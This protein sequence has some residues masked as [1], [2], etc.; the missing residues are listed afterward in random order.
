MN[1]KAVITAED[2]ATRVIKGFGQSINRVGKVAKIAAVAGI[3]ALTGAI[4]FSVKEAVESQKVTA[5]LEAV[6]KSTGK[7]AGIT[8]QAALD[9]ASSMQ[10]LTTFSDEEI[11]S[12]ENL[13]LTFTKI[14]KDIFPDTVKIVADMSTAL[15]QDLRSSS[16]QVGKALQDPILGVTALRRVGVNFNQTQTEVIK[17]LVKTGQSAEAQQ[18]ILK[19]LNLEF[20]GSAAAAA[21]TFGGRLKNLQNN[22]GEM[23]ETLGGLIIEQIE[24]FVVK[25]NDWVKNN[26]PQ[27]REALKQL[28]N[29]ISNISRKIG[30]VIAFIVK[31]KEAFIALGVLLL[32]V[33][34][35]GA[36][37]TVASNIRS[38][39][40]AIKGVSTA[41]Y[42]LA[43]ANPFALVAIAAV[44][45]AYLVVKAWQSALAA[46]EAVKN[47]DKAA[48][49]AGNSN[50]SVLRRLKDQIK[51]GT[52]AEQKRARSTLSGLTSN[53]TFSGRQH[54]GSVIGNKSYMVGERGPE[55]FVPPSGGGQI[56]P[57]SQVNR[58]A[59]TTINLSVNIGTFAGTPTERRKVAKDMLEALRDVASQQGTNLSALIAS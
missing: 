59:S 24:P 21:Q 29:A 38:I 17:N 58:N 16:I 56:V 57:N 27:I 55:M 45:A 9:L 46:I 54:G 36:I 12:A 13:L 32:S 44:G 28:V 42:A 22:F 34:V 19:E 23:A 51:N 39:A 25:L 7:T 31:W 10:Q 47:A 14:N 20:G 30:E 2:R 26:Q 50:D 53:G 40:L 6:L 52:P 5:Q 1:V 41:T 8:K 35:L 37:I 15:G 11:I 49:A 43:A 33:K 4:A 3:G 48:V 18:L